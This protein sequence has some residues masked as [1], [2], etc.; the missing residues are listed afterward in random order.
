MSTIALEGMKFQAPVGFYQ[1]EKRLGNEIVVDLY[2]NVSKLRQRD[3]LLEHTLNYEVIFETVKEVLTRPANLLET[4]SRQIIE[5]VSRLHSAIEAIEIRVAKLHPPVNG[6]VGRVF[7]EE[8]W[9][10]G[11]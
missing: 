6:T 9:V 11:G 10:R 8:E 5:E 7:V 3:D 4:V 1:E 2:V